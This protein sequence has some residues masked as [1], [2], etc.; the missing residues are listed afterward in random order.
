MNYKSTRE[1]TKSGLILALSIIIPSIFHM[2]GINGAIFLPMHIPVMVGAFFLSLPYA[3]VVGLLAPLLSSLLVGMPPLYPIAV[4]MIFELAVYAG[5]ISLLKDKVNVYVNLILSMFI[6]RIAAG[7][8]LFVLL[9]VFA[10]KFAPVTVY[11]KGA[12]TTG[13]PG[14]IVQIILIP[15]IIKVLRK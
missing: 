4:I 3:I 15:I 9:N 5:V 1:L 2:A 7:A 13:L 10:L 12:I 6:G 11:I 8:T 14:I